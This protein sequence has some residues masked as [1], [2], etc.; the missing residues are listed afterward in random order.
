MSDAFSSVVAERA[1]AGVVSRGATAERIRLV[2]KPGPRLVPPAV[3]T[4]LAV[5]QRLLR[6]MGD[7]EEAWADLSQRL[8][9]ENPFYT[10]AFAASAAQHLADGR[11]VTAV[12]VWGGAQDARV[13]L[14]LFPVILPRAGIVPAAARLWQPPLMAFGVPLVDRDNAETVIT[15]F[16]DHLGK[17]GLRGTAVLF[18]LLAEDGPFAVALRAVIGETGRQTRVFG[19]HRR[20]I[21]PASHNPG[22]FVT[23][24]TVRKRKELRRQLRRLEELDTVS[25]TRACDPVAVRDAVE[26]FLAIEA[27]GWKARAGT[28]ILQHSGAVAFLRTMTRRMAH[29]GRCE[30]HVLTIGRRAIAAGIVLR[31]GNEAFFWKIAYDEAFARFSPGVQLT[32]AL[33]HVQLDDRTI[34]YTDSCAI[35]NH[36][37]IDHL[38]R[39]R[40]SIADMLVGTRAGSSLAMR[41]LGQHEESRRKLRVVA[42]AVRC[43]IAGWFARG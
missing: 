5:E 31:S 28:A 43:R 42:K 4:P 40:L 41:V 11:H 20:A 2:P 38:W 13:L 7:Y 15:A 36:P 16:L 12:L 21:L 22:S 35:A 26:S 10:P 8:L 32:L 29:E 19:R 24:Q 18:P 39:E 33:S 6:N 34:A 3:E 25:F 9:Q 37:M 27:S 17:R 30:V 14:G 23:L 1:Q